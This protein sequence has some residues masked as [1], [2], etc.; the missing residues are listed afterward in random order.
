MQNHSPVITGVSIICSLGVDF[1]RVIRRI[2]HGKDRFSTI[3]FESRLLQNRRVAVVE[4]FN[5]RDHV[6]DGKT[7]RFMSRETR[8]A[9]CALVRCLEDAGVIVNETY[10]ESD[11]ALFAGTGSSGM[12]L[13][14]IEN[15]LDNASND[16]TGLFDPRKFGQV[17]LNRLNPLT[18]FKI[19]PNMPPSVAAIQ[20]GIKGANLIFNPWEG[21]ALLALFEAMHEI[22]S[23]RERIV[24]CGGSDCKTHSNAFLA[25][26]EYGLLGNEREPV[27]SEGSA[28]LAVET[29]FGA[30]KRNAEIYCNIKHISHRSN[31]S[32]SEAAGLTY[33][34]PCSE[35]LFSDMIEEALDESGL[36]PND[37][38]V[39]VSSNDGGKNDPMENRVIRKRFNDRPVLSPKKVIGNAFAASGIMNV[40]LAAFLLK[41]GSALI[42]REIHRILVH[43]F[44]PGS[45]QF[46]IVLEAPG[47]PRKN[48][49]P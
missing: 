37:I 44:A 7:L 9:V 16:D 8:F 4:D 47:E 25:F 30:K 45:E 42:Q 5:P 26:M 28:W 15:L 20:A 43:S 49:N 17:A 33:D 40:S 11:I 39:I 2:L 13:A 6:K 3:P 12:D 38:D 36:T 24:F 31:T 32:W 35:S 10:D 48:L 22:T 29:Y 27:L 41:N 34:Y 46:C 23:G 19:L 14:D 21:N 18:S 1:D